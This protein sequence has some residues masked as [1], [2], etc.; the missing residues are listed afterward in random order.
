MSR[1]GKQEIPIPDK[2]AVTV[3]D[4]R[5]TVKGAGGQ[6]ARALHPLVA[7]M[8]EEKILR[9]TRRDDSRLARSVHGL[10]RTLLA[11]M[12]VGVTEG[13]QRELDLVGVG[14]RAEVKGKDLQLALGYS[15][16]I[17]FPIPDG[18]KMQVEK[19]T[20][21]IVRG[22]DKELVGETA[23]RLRRLRLPEPY[24]GK[25]VRYADEVIRR[26]VGKAAV[27]AGGTK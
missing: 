10:T 8:V 3:A 24:K 18:I 19:Q 12:V 20:H 15:H 23:A 21:L 2:V 6:L 26:K 27:G 14:Y 25:G 13:F 1:V 22:A 11:N 17:L 4:G 16:P 9:V 5:I 7:A